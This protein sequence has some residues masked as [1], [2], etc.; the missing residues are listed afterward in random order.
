VGFVAGTFVLTDTM[1]K[2]FTDLFTQVS[3]GSDIIVRAEAAFTPSQFGP[4]GG[5]GDERNP[6]PDSVLSTV[7]A[8]PGVADAAGSVTGYAQMIDPAT[9]ETI[10]GVGPPTLGA[11]WSDSPTSP[12][13]LRQG[14]A[15]SGPT[16]VAVDAATAKTYGFSVGDRIKILFQG[17][18]QEFTIS[19]T[20]G[21][22]GCDARRV[23]HGDRANGARQG[24][25]V[26]PDRRRRRR[27][28]FGA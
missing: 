2:A 25:G 23:R 17:P 3:S 4:G 7:E 22:G 1:N 12:L 24:R 8:V 26:R 16:E 28:R 18:P 9:G 10:G 27:R 15:P 13:S 14:S 19:G 6:V 5:G 21:F 11:N 20:L